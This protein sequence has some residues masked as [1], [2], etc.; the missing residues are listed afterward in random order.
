MEMEQ[1]LLQIGGSCVAQSTCN[2]GATP[3]FSLGLRLD[4][5]IQPITLNWAVM[6]NQE[7]YL[8]GNSR[9]FVWL[10]VYWEVGI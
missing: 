5:C 7:R 1:L 8:N 2:I 9:V 10:Y 6:P 4:V 3:F